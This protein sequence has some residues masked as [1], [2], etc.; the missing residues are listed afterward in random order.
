MPKKKTWKNCR[1]LPNPPRNP[2]P[3]FPYNSCELTLHFMQLCS[4][5]H[6]ARVRQRAAQHVFVIPSNFCVWRQKPFAV[7]FGRE[8]NQVVFQTPSKHISLCIVTSVQEGTFC[9]NGK[10]GRLRGK[11]LGTCCYLPEKHQKGQI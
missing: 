4:L 11:G 7:G 6:S 8:P 1:F 3:L 9:R 5:A 2:P 10:G